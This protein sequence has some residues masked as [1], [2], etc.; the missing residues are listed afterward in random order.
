M[1][2]YLESYLIHGSLPWLYVDGGSASP[3]HF[4]LNDIMSHLHKEVQYIEPYKRFHNACINLKIE[5]TIVIHS[6]V[7][8]VSDFPFFYC[9]PTV[10]SPETSLTFVLILCYK[11]P[12]ISR[13]RSKQS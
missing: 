2:W 8:S 13:S 6:M 1:L 4:L 9:E 11:V 5:S 3:I 10:K 7:S 12:C